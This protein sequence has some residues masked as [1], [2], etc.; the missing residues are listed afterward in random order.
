MSSRFIESLMNELV[1]ANS[2]E[3]LLHHY[4]NCVARTGRKF[5]TFD[6]DNSHTNIIGSS[7]ILAVSMLSIQILRGTNSGIEPT[8]VLQLIDKSSEIEKHLHEVG[9]DLKLEDVS[10]AEFQRV[11]TESVS[12]W[13][14]LEEIGIPRVAKYKLLARKRPALFPI[15]DTVM[16]RQLGNP[17][18]WYENWFLAF[19]DKNLDLK[20]RLGLIR[21][22]VAAA[23]HL[24]LLR[25]ADI[26][27]WERQQDLCQL[28]SCKEERHQN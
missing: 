27:I 14:I 16:E 23:S 13:K 18:D 9:V 11:L 10:V 4:M 20:H 28:D 2:C 17:E 8:K 25:V 6:F 22:K 15:R 26:V 7:D 12:I 3:Q 24:S 5:E 19:Q 1:D 21:E